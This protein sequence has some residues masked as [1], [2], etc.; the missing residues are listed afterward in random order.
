[1][2]GRREAMRIIATVSA[3]FASGSAVSQEPMPETGEITRSL[4]RFF[5]ALKHDKYDVALEMF[6]KDG[7]RGMGSSGEPFINK[8]TI[9]QYL[10]TTT[11]GG[12]MIIADGP[13]ILDELLACVR[14]TEVF[15]DSLIQILGR[16]WLFVFGLQ[17]SS[18]GI[19]IIRLNVIQIN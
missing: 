4:Y 10:R 16:E 9:E 6:S 8:E 19:S 11:F 5:D 17:P 14:W 12:T 18:A 1:M 15:P 7:V 3:L 2:I 13:V